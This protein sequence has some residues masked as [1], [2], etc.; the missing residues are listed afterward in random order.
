M[1][2]PQRITVVRKKCCLLAPRTRT[3]TLDLLLDLFYCHTGSADVVIV[4]K[5]ELNYHGNKE[6]KWKPI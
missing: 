1:W 5:L 3:D 6:G 4:V 2:E